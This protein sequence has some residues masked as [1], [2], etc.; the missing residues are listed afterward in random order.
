MR[1]GRWSCCGLILRHG[2]GNWEKLRSL[3]FDA[4]VSTACPRIAVDDVAMYDKPLLTPQELEIVLGVRKWENYVFDQMTED[5][6]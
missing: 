2:V 5:E 6:L 1:S 3:G 4:Y